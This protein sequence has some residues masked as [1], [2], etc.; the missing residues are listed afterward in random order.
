MKTTS[1]LETVASNKP[2]AVAIDK[3]AFAARWG[4]SRRMVDNFLAQGMPHLAIGTR[5]VRII[6]AE[7]DAWMNDRYATRRRRAA[8]NPAN[9][10]E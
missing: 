6:P 3:G 7:G 4:V 9:K 2:T 5:R 1:Q 8:T 10:S